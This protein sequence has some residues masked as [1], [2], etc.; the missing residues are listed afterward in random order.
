MVTTQF[1]TACD[2]AEALVKKFANEIADESPVIQGAAIA[3][4]LAHHLA[5]VAPVH[6]AD[7]RNTLVGLADELVPTI[8]RA[9]I[10]DGDAPPEW[11]RQS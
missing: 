5:A 9:A 6:R 11:D 1:E 3:I 8:L 4:L 2:A 10:R 7:V